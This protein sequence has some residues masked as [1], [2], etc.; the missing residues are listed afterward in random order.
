MIPLMFPGVTTVVRDN[1]VGYSTPLT[2]KANFLNVGVT[3]AE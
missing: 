1:V 2:G 3:P